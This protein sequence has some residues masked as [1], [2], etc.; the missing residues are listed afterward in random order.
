MT[1]AKLERIVERQ[2]SADWKALVTGC[3]R[4]VEAGDKSYAY[5][6]ASALKDALGMGGSEAMD[7]VSDLLKGGGVRPSLMKR[8][9]ALGEL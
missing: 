8:Y 5:T 1:R 2:L 7:A 4:H 6:A 9:P 3:L